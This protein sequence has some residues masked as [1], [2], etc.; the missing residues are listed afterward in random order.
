VLQ[1]N[2]VVHGMDKMLRGLIGEDVELSTTF[3][4]RWEI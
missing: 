2:E 1:L 3:D 4:Q